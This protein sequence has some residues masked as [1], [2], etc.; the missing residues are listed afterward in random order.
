MLAEINRKTV[1]GGSDY[2]IVK[3]DADGNKIWDKT[4]GSVGDDF[5]RTITATSEG[6]IVIAGTSNSNA[7]GDKSENSK[8]G[9]DYW[10]V[11]IDADGN[12]IWDKTIG[13]VGNEFYPSITATSEGAIVI[14]GTSES[15]AIGDKSEN[16]KG[17]D[18]H[19]IVKIDA[20]GNKIWDKTIGS[21]GDDRWPR[22][23]A[24]SE[25]AIVIAG[26]SDSNAS[27]DKSENSKGGNDYW[28][29][30]I[31]ADGNKIW[32]KTIGSVGD[33]RYP[34]IT[35][36]SE[37]AIVIAGT[38]NSNASGDKS[39]NSK[40]GSDYWIVKIDADGNKIWDKTIGSVGNDSNLASIVETN[41]GGFVVAGGSWS[42]AGGDK[43]ENSKG[44]SDHWIVK[45][46]ADGNKIWD[47]TIGTNSEDIN[48][49]TTFLSS[50]GVGIDSL[51][52]I[53]M[54]NSGFQF[55]PT[56]SGDKTSSPK[57]GLDIWVIKLS[58]N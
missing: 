10:I 33:D 13:S 57:G 12:K 56:T 49:F 39:E 41:E 58:A 34:R 21:V 8:G 1:R 20:D 38:S 17:G 37:G 7:S 11:K 29:V 46:D 4:I 42:N 47:K 54:Y 5:C 55:G 15:N 9:G 30:K 53:Y 23:T 51:D 52:N 28:I 16:S 50:W 26:T 43:S 19:W 25:G 27:G 45:I 18:D 24:T 31:D 40:G 48:L 35:A 3:I 14:A 22:I 6:A 2:W 32:D 44:G 36:T